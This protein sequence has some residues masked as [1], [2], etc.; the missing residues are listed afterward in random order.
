[1]A[2]PI[3][4]PGSPREP[5]LPPCQAPFSAFSEYRQEASLTSSSVCRSMVLRRAHSG[6][7]CVSACFP[8]RHQLLRGRDRGFPCCTPPSSRPS[9]QQVTGMNE[10][11]KD[12]WVG[13]WMERDSLPHILTERST[14]KF[15]Q[16]KTF[17]P[18]QSKQPRHNCTRKPRLGPGDAPNPIQESGLDFPQKSICLPLT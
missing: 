18:L 14:E 6:T 5:A 9:P 10:C 2:W 3:P 11:T 8:G 16:Q 13:G 15:L 7:L 12:G 17:S 4:P 1:M